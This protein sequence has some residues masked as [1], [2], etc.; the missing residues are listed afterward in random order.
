M[1]LI[2]DIIGWLRRRPTPPRPPSPPVPDTTAEQLLDEHNVRRHRARSGQPLVINPALMQSAQ[3]HARDMAEHHNL[4]HVGSDGSEVVT[5]LHRAGWD[6]NYWGENIAEG[7][8]SV[9]QVMD[10]WWNSPGHRTNI[11]NPSYTQVGFAVA[12]GGGAA[13]WCADFGN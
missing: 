3:D 11:L 10:S 8:T 2:S 5:R 4:S 12:Y 7:Q 1:G 13:Y 6:G 9:G